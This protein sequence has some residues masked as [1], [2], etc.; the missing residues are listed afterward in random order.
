MKRITHNSQ[1]SHNL[2]TQPHRVVKQLVGRAA[3][4]LMS[5]VILGLSSMPAQAAFLRSIE[6][7]K[8]EIDL[9]F[10]EET[11]QEQKEAFE[12]AG[13]FW[14][15]FLDDDETLT[16]YVDMSDDFLPE[17]ILGGSLPGM[18]ANQQ[19]TNFKSEYQSDISSDYD[20][21]AHDNMAAGDQ[22]QAVVQSPTGHQT[23]QKT[24]V[25][26]TRAAAKAV[27]L[28]EN[29]N[30][31]YDDWDGY[32]TMNSSFNWSYDVLNGPGDNEVD[33]F[34]VAIHELGHQL[35]FTSVVDRIVSDLQNN[36]SSSSSSASVSSSSSSSSS[37][38]SASSSS[39]GSSSFASASSS[40][41]GSGSSSFASA[42]SSSSSG[43][44]SSS[45]ATAC[46][47]TDNYSAI[48]DDF[49]SL[50]MV[51]EG[52]INC[53]EVGTI[54]TINA[55]MT[56]NAHALDLFRY[57]QEQGSTMDLTLN[58]D[59]KYFS[60]DKQNAIATDGTQVYE[61]LA[62]CFAFSSNSGEC[63]TAY[64]SKGLL[65]V[66]QNGNTLGDGYQGSHWKQRLQLGTDHAIGIMDPALGYGT[67]REITALDL[68]AFDVAGWDLA[69]GLE[70]MIE[71][72]QIIFDREALVTTLWDEAQQQAANAQTM[73]RD[74]AEP[75]IQSMLRNSRV[76][77]N[78]W[79][80]PWLPGCQG[81][82]GWQTFLSQNLLAQEVIASEP[83]KVPEPTATLG[84]LG[85]GLLGLISGWKR[86]RPKSNK[87]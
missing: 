50:A 42:S 71:T 24:T 13:L 38:A 10:S 85:F 8:L 47:T 70:E 55:G 49:T 41:S 6:D 73:A 44:G 58:G 45:F 25:D 46:A 35:G 59:E 32:I 22:Y 68:I 66:D 61:N 4:V 14:S 3:Q 79:L 30:A 19:Y 63:T 31:G 23:Q 39:S 81:G 82:G 37:F 18:Q 75:V 83:E 26:M 17:N 7:H 84:L 87:P 52:T 86:D 54:D 74:Q 43:S 80:F 20:Q 72:G 48:N 2:D 67:T 15:N 64:F 51:E 27:G 65:I 77:N 5:T 16:F 33:F 53:V 78:C 56:Q 1:V 9:I 62:D 69:N 11:T 40:S 28:L 60:I 12:L 21:S 34:S 36:S 76:Y 57:S 29:S